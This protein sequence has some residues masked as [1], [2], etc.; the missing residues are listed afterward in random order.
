MANSEFLG[1]NTAG[2]EKIV[3]AIDAYVKKVNSVS[4]AATAQETQVFA[5]GSSSYSAMMTMFR[6]TDTQMANLVTNKLTPLKTRIQNLSNQ[7]KSNDESQ[8]ATMNTNAKSIL[9]S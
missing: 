6:N 1:L 2:A 8:A 3:A 4:F 7:Y 5:K 9:K